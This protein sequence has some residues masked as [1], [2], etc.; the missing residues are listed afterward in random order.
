MLSIFPRDDSYY[1]MSGVTVGNGCTPF[2]GPDSPLTPMTLTDSVYDS[3]LLST[4]ALFALV[5]SLCVTGP[6][7]VDSPIS[8][9]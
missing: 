8:L 9:R 5:C 1:I 4:L 7:N 6:D 2:T 3:Q